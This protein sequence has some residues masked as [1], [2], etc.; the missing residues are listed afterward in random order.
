MSA[1]VSQPGSGR[2][3]SAPARKPLPSW[4]NWCAD[5]SENPRP[6]KHDSH[7]RGDV[8]LEL[9]FGHAGCLEILPVEIGDAVFLQGIERQAAAAGRRRNAEAGDLGEDIRAEH[10]RV[11]GD[12]RAPIMADND[13]LLFAERRHQRDHVADIVEDACRRRYR[14]ARWCGRT[15][16][17]R[18]RRHGNR[19]PRSQGSGAARNRIVPA[20]R[21]RA[22]RADPGPVREQRTQFRWRKWCVR[23]A[24]RFRP[25]FR[26]C[27]RDCSAG[28][29]R[30]FDLAPQ[31]D[32]HGDK[33][34]NLCCLR[35]F[36]LLE[37]TDSGH[38]RWQPRP[39]FSANPTPR[40]SSRGA[41]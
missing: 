24:S 2:W 19:P 37:R 25:V 7:R 15:R 41:A 14:Q 32:R 1:S 13:G 18:G 3:G 5:G 29:I 6:P 34:K 36:Q 17:Y 26:I 23:M 27:V 20:S 33:S 31:S 30:S 22:P 21:G 39:P 11:P 35:Y 16:A 4:T 8:A 10:R 38:R 40:P 9:G 12:R 28:T